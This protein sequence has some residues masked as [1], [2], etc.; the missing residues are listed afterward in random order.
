MVIKFYCTNCG[1]KLSAEENQSGLSMPCPNCS[2]FITVPTFPEDAEVADVSM[3]KNRGNNNNTVEFSKT[4]FNAAINL[5]KHNLLLVTVIL[6]PLIGGIILIFFSG[7]DNSHHYKPIP[8]QQVST[9][10]GMPANEPI[11]ITTQSDFD[12][13]LFLM[14]LLENMYYALGKCKST[15]ELTEKLTSLKYYTLRQIK[16]IRLKKYDDSLVALYDSFLNTLDNYTNFLISIGKIKRAVASRTE[17]ER[18]ESGYDA[19]YQGGQV[20]AELY[21]N[22][23]SGSQ[24]IVAGLLTTVIKGLWDDHNKGIERDAAE[25]DSSA[26]CYRELENDITDF[27]TS[28]QIVA[29]NLE[30]KYHWKNGEA[31]FEENPS[32]N[33][34][35]AQLVKAQN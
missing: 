13:R 19:G 27:E 10:L 17:K 2:S 12:E 9:I 20:G 11:E 21:N 28:A 34:D 30:D 31:G 26:A 5:S 8:A 32:L 23:A 16:Y 25:Q 7:A 24:A 29:R 18:I 6:I 35:I 14:N 22:G 1:Q 3:I 4:L 33:E 15:T